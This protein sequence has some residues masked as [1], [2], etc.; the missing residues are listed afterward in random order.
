MPPARARGRAASRQTAGNRRCEPRSRRETSSFP[1]RSTPW[2]ASRSPPPGRNRTARRR[3]DR[4]SARR[5]TPSSGSR[6]LW[7]RRTMLSPLWFRLCRVRARLFTIMHNQY[8]NTVRR[9]IREESTIDIEQMSSSLVA[10]TDPTA[11]RQLRELE[12][13]LACLPGEQREVI[14]LVGLEGMSYETAAQVLSVPVGTVRSRLSRGRD[15]L[16]RLMDIPERGAGATAQASR[17]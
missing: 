1:R 12:R 17:A 4:H 3:S 8:V 15:A 5:A 9:A 14:L 6:Q 16:R 2:E 10:T 11:S 13:A 7:H